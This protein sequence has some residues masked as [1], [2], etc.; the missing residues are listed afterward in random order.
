M[1][2][3]KF[4]LALVCTA[5]SAAFSGDVSRSLPQE[6]LF[7]LYP[8]TYPNDKRAVADSKQMTYYDPEGAL[9]AGGRRHL[10]AERPY[11]STATAKTSTVKVVDKCEGCAGDTIDVTK[12]VFGVLVDLNLGRVQVTWEWP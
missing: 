4:L 9:G 11:G 3:A 8:P 6:E 12:T 2:I 7:P 5:S 1:A 10:A